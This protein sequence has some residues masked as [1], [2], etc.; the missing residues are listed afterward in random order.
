[1][2]MKLV[3][4]FFGL[5]IYY[6]AVDSLLNTPFRSLQR[7]KPRCSSSHRMKSL[8]LFR[9]DCEA[10]PKLADYIYGADKIEMCKSHRIFSIDAPK[11]DI[12]SDLIF[13]AII[14]LAGYLSR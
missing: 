10:F 13:F 1:M 5:L 12:G 7:I 9:F 6:S 4:A 11:F 14:I 2:K 3:F 8:K